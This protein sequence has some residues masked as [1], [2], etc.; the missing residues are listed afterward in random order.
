MVD[1]QL[2]REVEEELRKER[3]AAVWDRYGVMALIG[4]GVILLGIFGYLWWKNSNLAAQQAAGDRFIEALKLS[5]QDK[6]E[7]ALKV[8]QA[9]SSDSPSGYQALSQLHLA[10]LYA[11]QGQQD[12][13]AALYKKISGDPSAD[14]ILSDYAKLNLALLQLDGASF[15][16]TLKGLS[17]F[18]DKKS[19]WRSLALEV[20]ALAAMKDGKLDEAKARFA[21]IVAD[22][23]APSSLKRRAQ[24]LLDVIATAAARG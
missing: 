21:E 13:A 24:I 19:A 15:D 16:A 9:L 23:T 7:D 5:S 12:E 17:A 8:F 22:K 11:D 1:D 2:F 6:N 4:L 18:L 14:K 10:S 3:L 20:V